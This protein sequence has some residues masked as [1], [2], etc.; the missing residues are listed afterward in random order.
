MRNIFTN[1]IIDTEQTGPNTHAHSMH[2]LGVVKLT[3]NLNE[4]FEGKMRPRPGTTFDPVSMKYAGNVTW[5]ELLTWPDPALVIPKFGDWIKSTLEPG[6]RALF[7]A[8][9]NGHDKKWLDLYMDQ[10]GSSHLTGHTSRNINDL[11]RGFKE[12]LAAAGKP[13]PKRYRGLKS[14]ADTPHDHTPV[15]DSKGLCEALIKLHDDVGFPIVIH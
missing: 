15:N 14:L 9:N 3:R 10:Y 13:L 4:A 2:W 5:D 11:F 6:T 8:D 1:Y 7:W 12:G